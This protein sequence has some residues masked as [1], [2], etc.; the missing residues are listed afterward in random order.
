MGSPAVY[1]A[2][3]QS[4]GPLALLLNVVTESQAVGPLAWARQLDGP[5]A[6]VCS[7]FVPNVS[8]NTSEHAEQTLRRRSRDSELTN[9]RPSTSATPCAWH[10]PPPD[11]E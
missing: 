1:F 5:L 6:R 7:R 2:L 4:A 8:G 11:R 10:S 9:V 3:L